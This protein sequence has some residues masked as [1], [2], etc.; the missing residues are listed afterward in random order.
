MTNMSRENAWELSWPIALGVNSVGQTSDHN[1]R[2]A[3]QIQS[4]CKKN[5]ISDI[6]VKRS[7]R[8][9]VSR[10]TLGKKSRRLKF[11]GFELWRMEADDGDGGASEEPGL[12]D[13]LRAEDLGVIEDLCVYEF[14]GNGSE[15][16]E[17]DNEVVEDNIEEQSSKRERL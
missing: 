4:N 15:V 14:A 1:W 6:V 16:V 11:G 8:S 10:R 7:M 17:S 2:K 9:R 3:D 12:E 5:A 13:E